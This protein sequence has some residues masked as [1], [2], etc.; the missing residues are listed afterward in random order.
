[1]SSHK[2]GRK[3]SFWGWKYFSKTEEKSSSGISLFQCLVPVGKDKEGKDV[4]C[5]ELVAYGGSPTN[6]K[7]HFKGRH[8]EWHAK[9]KSENIPKTAKKQQRLDEVV[10]VPSPSSSGSLEP[11]PATL[12]EKAQLDEDLLSYVVDDLRGVSSVEGK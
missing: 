2:R 10:K 6:F 7:N 5:C 8:R 9:E 11:R 4:L 1:M 3:S 12:E